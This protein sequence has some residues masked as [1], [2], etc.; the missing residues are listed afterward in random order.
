MIIN[1][2]TSILSPLTLSLF[3]GVVV[4]FKRK[5]FLGFIL[6]DRYKKKK[7]RSFS[8]FPISSPQTE[9]CKGGFTSQKRLLKTSELYALVEGIKKGSVRGC[10][11][12]KY[13][14]NIR[15]KTCVRVLD[16]EHV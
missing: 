7:N 16:L 11:R 13:S 2:T 6:A 12:V 4:C 10:V 8:L 5:V 9:F 1:P 15:L 3:L 14:Y